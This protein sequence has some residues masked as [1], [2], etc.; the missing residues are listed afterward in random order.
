MQY[1]SENEKKTVNEIKQTQQRKV[2]GKKRNLK[3]KIKSKKNKKSNTSC[4]G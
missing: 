2:D 3:N 1:E 4:V